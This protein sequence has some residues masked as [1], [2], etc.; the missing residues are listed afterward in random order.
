MTLKCYSPSRFLS[1]ILL[2]QPLPFFFPNSSGLRRGSGEA[3]QPDGGDG[4][5]T[6]LGF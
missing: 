6:V 4:E 2:L 3:D 1:L 5:R